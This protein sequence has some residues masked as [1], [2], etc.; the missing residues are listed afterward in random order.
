MLSAALKELIV[1][2]TLLLELTTP[3]HEVQCNM[4]SNYYTVLCA[5][6]LQHQ[7]ICFAAY[8]C[9]PENSLRSALCNVTLNSDH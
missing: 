1:A 2:F 3:S 9:Q 7:I 5:T 4:R 8:R 6:S